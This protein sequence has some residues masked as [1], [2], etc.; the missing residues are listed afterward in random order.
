MATL[1][2]LNGSFEELG[3]VL[4]SIVISTILEE[5]SKKFKNLG[6]TFL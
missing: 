5:S 2:I 4:S 1:V 3:K 6:G